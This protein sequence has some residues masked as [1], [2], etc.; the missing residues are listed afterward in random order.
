MATVEKHAPGEFCWVELGTSSA[1]GARAFYPELFGWE[2]DDMEMPGNG[3]YTMFKL[4]GRELGAMWELT[5]AMR[6][7]GVPPHWLLYVATASVDETLRKAAELGGQP[8]MGPH[9]VG[10]AGRMAVLRDPQGA[11]FAV[12]EARGHIG[13]RIENELGVM[14]WPELATSDAAG[15]RAF[16]T[17]LF[18]WS[19]KATPMGPI[20]YTEWSLDGKPNGGMFPMTAEFGGIPPHWM[21]YFRVADCDRIAARVKELA[22]EVKVP[23]TPIPNIGRFSVLADPQGAVFSIVEIAG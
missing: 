5:E 7:H 11:A 14:T 6:A 15:A 8:L 13:S 19:A 23:P 9:D 22:G 12:W 16:Y 10:G 1:S 17:G 4:G 3:V 2:L 21:P 18:G 20:E